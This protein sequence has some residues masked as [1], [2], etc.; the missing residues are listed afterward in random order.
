[1]ISATSDLLTSALGK[2]HRFPYNMEDIF[3]M[4]KTRITGL[5]E[6]HIEHLLT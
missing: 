2:H 4:N 6:H 3:C 1:M 5:A